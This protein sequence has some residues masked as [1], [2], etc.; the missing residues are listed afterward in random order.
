MNTDVSTGELFGSLWPEYSP[1][2]FEDSV[3]LWD[4]RANANNF[5]LLKQ[6]L[7]RDMQN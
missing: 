3:R 2:E 6:I 5:D 4:K 7:K 1:K